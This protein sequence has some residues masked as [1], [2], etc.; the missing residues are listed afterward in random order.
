MAETDLIDTLV[1]I[2]PGSPLDVIRAGRAVARHHSQES[3]R[4]LFTPDAPGDVSRHER[5]AIGAYVAAL[6]GAADLVDHYAAEATAPDLVAAAAAQTRAI[7]PTGRFP[8]GPLSLED[9]AAPAFHLDAATA[10]A[11]GPRLAT[12]LAHAHFLV[13][14]PR[15]A[16][17]AAFEPLLAAGWTVDGLVTLSQIV[18]FLT[19]QI[20]VV[21]G[22]R[23]LAGHI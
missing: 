15:D 17:P 12:A 14:H 8:A 23:V 1:G 16:A 22:L 7:G 9:T 11:L 5:F 19:Y 10:A 21:H 13:F 6:H 18:S 2:A 3:Y 20:R 4:V